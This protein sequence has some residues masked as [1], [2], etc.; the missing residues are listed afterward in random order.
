MLM[1]EDEL[2]V[3]RQENVLLVPFVFGKDSTY[4]EI[5]G[6]IKL[7][8][9]WDNVNKRINNDMFEYVNSLIVPEQ[10]ENLSG[11]IKEQ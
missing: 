5:I 10:I 11:D 6:K 2:K 4:E 9:Y 3:M 1:H 8:G 7:S